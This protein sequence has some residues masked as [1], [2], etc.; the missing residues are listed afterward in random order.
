MSTMT[1]KLPTNYVDV[2]REEM[3]YVDGGASG[4]P[5]W[6]F[7]SGFNVFVSTIASGFGGIGALILAV[8]KSEAKKIFKRNAAKST[9]MIAIGTFLGSRV[10]DKAIDFA[11]DVL[12][13]GSFVANWLDSIDHNRNN[14]YI[15]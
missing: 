15:W 10:L 11:L 7:K 6:L 4:I 3:E 9:V 12:D 1:L 13:P 8:G 5:K 14:G 2:D